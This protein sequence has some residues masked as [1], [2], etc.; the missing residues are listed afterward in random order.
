MFITVFVYYIRTWNIV[1]Q[2]TEVETSVLTC[3]K[4]V[5]YI[6][7]M[8][9]L[10]FGYFSSFI[11]EQRVASPDAMVCRQLGASRG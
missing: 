9:G 2:V 10:K 8:Q 4:S 6:L 7:F 5:I 11:V 1:I 3:V